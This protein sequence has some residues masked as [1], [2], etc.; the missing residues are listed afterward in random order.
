MREKPDNGNPRKS[1]SGKTPADSIFKYRQNRYGIKKTA[2]YI[3]V[4]M[5]DCGNH[6]YRLRTQT[7][8]A[9][10][11]LLPTKSRL[12]FTKEQTF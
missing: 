6:F 7:G 9:A 3:P 11:P 1:G 10:Y 8:N 5:I 2:M 12:L 4:F